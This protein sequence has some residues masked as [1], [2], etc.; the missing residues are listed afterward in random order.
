MKAFMLYT[1]SIILLCIYN[2]EK[3]VTLRMYY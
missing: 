3:L 1:S 2:A